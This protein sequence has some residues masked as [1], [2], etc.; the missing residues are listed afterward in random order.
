MNM[1]G[2]SLRIPFVGDSLADLRQEAGLTQHRLADLLLTAGA[3]QVSRGAV[4][5]WETG[6]NKPLPETFVI[7]LRVLAAELEMPVAH[8]RSQLG[9]RAVAA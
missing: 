3:T 9:S 2:R 6:R 8:I 1:S 5:G 4:A 7:L